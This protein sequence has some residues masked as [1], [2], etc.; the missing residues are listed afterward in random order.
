MTQLYLIQM[1][2]S[3]KSRL[4]RTDMFLRKDRTLKDKNEGGLYYNMKKSKLQRLAYIQDLT[5]VRLSLIKH[6][7]F[8]YKD[9]TC[10]FE[11]FRSSTM[12]HK[13]DI[14]LI[15]LNMLLQATT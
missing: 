6:F 3:L 13:C 5:M 11:S 1:Y 8:P 10:F 12:T 7:P 4:Y 2:L 14:S 9:L 15:D